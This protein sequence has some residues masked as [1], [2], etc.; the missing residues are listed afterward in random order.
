MYLHEAIKKAQEEKGKIALPHD[1]NCDGVGFY[2]LAMPISSVLLVFEYRGSKAIADE[3]L[4][5]PKEMVR[6]DW[7]VVG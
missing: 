5:G 1:E 3:C 7:M 4:L 2:F 6:D